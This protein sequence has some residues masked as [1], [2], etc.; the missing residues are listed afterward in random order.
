MPINCM[1]AGGISKWTFHSENAPH[2]FR[3]H[4]A[5]KIWERNNHRSLRDFF[6]ERN[7]GRKHHDYRKLVAFEKSRFSKYFLSKQV[8]RKPSVFW[9]FRFEECFRDWLAWTGDLTEKIKSVRFQIPLC[10]FNTVFRKIRTSPH[11]D[12]LPILGD[13]V[14]VTMVQLIFIFF[15]PEEK[16]ASLN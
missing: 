15:T 12:S 5:G 2:V 6:F 7:P 3:P 10:W 14:K 11:W 16:D 1:Y 13:D 8:K 9:F 4:C